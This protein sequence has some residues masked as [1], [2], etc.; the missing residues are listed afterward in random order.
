MAKKLFAKSDG[1]INYGCF[2]VG[3]FTEGRITEGG[4]WDWDAF[5]QNR[6]E[7]GMFG[8]VAPGAYSEAER[9]QIPIMKEIDIKDVK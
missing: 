7:N 8:T 3:N 6:R 1:D 2:L 9:A 4:E 5:L